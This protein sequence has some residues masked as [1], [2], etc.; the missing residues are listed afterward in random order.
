MALPWC[1]AAIVF[2]RRL[3]EMTQTGHDTW[4]SYRGQS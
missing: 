4:P 2:M 1:T 3:D